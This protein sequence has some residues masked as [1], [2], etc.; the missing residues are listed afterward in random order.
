MAGGQRGIAELGV[1][2]E[3]ARCIEHDLARAGRRI[4]ERPDNLID[5]FGHALIAQFAHRIL[6][7]VGGKP[8]RRHG[9]HGDA[10]EQNQEDAIGDR[11]EQASHS[12]DPIVTVVDST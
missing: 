6:P 11:V 5:A 4:V 1:E 7:F 10:C 12:G 9:S 2:P 3:I 8:G